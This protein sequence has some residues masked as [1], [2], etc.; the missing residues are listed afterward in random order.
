MSLDWREV[1]RRRPG[2]MLELTADERFRDVGARRLL[3]ALLNCAAA[4]VMATRR[5]K[6]IAGRKR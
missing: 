3:E 6:E 4:K 2:T 1:V 5:A